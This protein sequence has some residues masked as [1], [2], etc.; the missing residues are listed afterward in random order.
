MQATVAVLHTHV[1][2]VILFLILFTAKAVMLFLN[3]HSL[4]DK[5]KRYTKALDM[6]FGTL[7]LVTG[8][9]LLYL[10]Q[11]M[12]GWLIIK[13]VLV[14]LAIPL[15]I[16]GIKRHSKVL[17]ALALLIFLYVYGVAETKSLTMRTP[18]P[19]TNATTDDDSSP[20][21]DAAET[22]T[23]NID[24][25]NTTEEMVATIADAQLANAKAI[26][27]QV[28][29]TC[30]GPDG[31]KGFG[32]AANLKVSNLSLQD[33]IN[34]VENGRGLMPGFGGQLTEQEAE[35]LAAYTMTLK[36]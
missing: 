21:T 27:T 31:A 5:A 34:V 12:Q 36:K 20:I 28:C 29:E 2:V 32:G 19:V 16:I 6:V 25:K 13:I 3:K 35:A 4:L 18:G 9:Y 33:R 8:G 14:L 11:G 23:A 15:G 17:T 10:Y 26:Y 7:I 22:G 24:S 30:H 1:L